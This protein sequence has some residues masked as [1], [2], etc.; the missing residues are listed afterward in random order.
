[1]TTTAID[2]YDDSNEGFQQGEKVRIVSGEH[3]GKFGV[4]N[5]VLMTTGYYIVK[6]DDS[7]RLALMDFHEIEPIIEPV[8]AKEWADAPAFGLSSAQ[9]AEEVAE[10]ITRATS[11]VTGVG[12]DQYAE[13]G[14]QGF[15]TMKL[16]DLIEYQL[17]E[18]D[19]VINYSVM[20]QIRLRRTLAELRKRGVV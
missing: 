6:P 17:E 10:A 16:D 4:I 20:L 13:Q 2:S 7:E 5:E 11:R 18:L 12:H 3:A 9:L 8:A 19:D 15:E 1:M 14:R